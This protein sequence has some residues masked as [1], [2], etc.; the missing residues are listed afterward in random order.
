MKFN[1]FLVFRKMNIV[2][3]YIDFGDLRSAA[4]DL[5]L[6]CLPMSKIGVSKNM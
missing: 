5:G 6:H 1:I 2:L 3:G 4:S